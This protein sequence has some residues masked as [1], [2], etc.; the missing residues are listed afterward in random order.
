LTHPP[1][2]SR[3]LTLDRDGVAGAAVQ[4]PSP[5]SDERPQHARVRLI[6]VHNISLPPGKFGGPAIVAL[7]TNRLDPTAHPYYARIAR[8]RVSAHFLIR[9]DGTLI[10]FVPCNQRAWHA[11]E[12]RW[13]GRSR[14]NDFSVG[15]ELEG[16]DRQPYGAAQYATLAR[17]TRALLRRYPITAVVGH[18]DVAPGRKSDPGPAF[19]W[20]R[21]RRGIAVRRPGRVP[22]MPSNSKVK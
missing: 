10:Q 6:V 12:S 18:R 9:R 22:W 2:A 16:T 17:I 3:C 19:D 20:E 21:Y 11:G 7:F 14:C 1:L 13:R 4:I 5:N 15:I 8:L